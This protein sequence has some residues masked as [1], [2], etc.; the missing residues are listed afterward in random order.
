MFFEELKDLIPSRHHKITKSISTVKVGDLETTRSDGDGQE[1]FYIDPQ[2]LQNAIFPAS[3]NIALIFCVKNNEIKLGFSSSHNW[4]LFTELN[5]TN[6]NLPIWPDYIPGTVHQLKLALQQADL[7][8]LA[9]IQAPISPQQ[10]SAQPLT[11]APAPI[12]TTTAADTSTSSPLALPPAPLTVGNPNQPHQSQPTT[13]TTGTDAAAVS[14]MGN[15]PEPSTAAVTTTAA[16]TTTS[17]AGTATTTPALSSSQAAA[18][19][20]VPT[21]QAQ[22][23]PDEEPE[24]PAKK[25]FSDSIRFHKR[26]NPSVADLSLEDTKKVFPIFEDEQQLASFKKELQEQPE[27]AENLSTNAS[28]YVTQLQEDS[29]LNLSNGNFCSQ[30]ADEN[31]KA[32]IKAI[33]ASLESV[34]SLDQTA[35]TNFAEALNAIAQLEENNRIIKPTPPPA[36]EYSWDVATRLLQNAALKG[37]NV[38]SF[39]S[40]TRNKPRTTASNADNIFDPSQAQIKLG[41]TALEKIAQFGDRAQDFAGYGNIYY[42]GKEDDIGLAIKYDE[43]KSPVI[44]YIQNADQ[45]FMPLKLEDGLD[46]DNYVKRLRFVKKYT[47]AAITLLEKNQ[48]PD[49]TAEMQARPSLSRNQPPAGYPT[50]T[51]ISSSAHPSS[52]PAVTTHRAT[53]FVPTTG[54]IIAT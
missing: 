7:Q 27:F 46:P 20:A 53:A 14:T 6:E 12:V 37:E 3:G 51:P 26:N 48:H 42:L 21:V 1:F 16:D 8:R 47:T 35:G 30:S 25:H 34:K 41:K 29:T 31:N 22:P 24:D 13:T 10:L 43:G 15:A 19:P 11:M 4:N 9:T 54:R 18:Q 39:F 45:K 28:D 50:P 17:A 32:K 5:I 52:S 33:K 49:F 44:G 36:L 2:F 40:A 23:A 38:S